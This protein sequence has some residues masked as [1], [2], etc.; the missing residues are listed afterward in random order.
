MERNTE[1]ERVAEIFVDDWSLAITNKWWLDDPATV[2][3][4]TATCDWLGDSFVRLQAE[5]DGKPTWDFVFGRN[6]TSDQFVVL[7][8]DERGVL[9]ESLRADRRRCRLRRCCAPT[10]TSINASSATSKATASS[11]TRMPLRIKGPPG[12]IATS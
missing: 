5:I 7:Y 12:A 9:C 8:H 2:T 10:P 11:A 1:L 4:G 6:D 3:Y